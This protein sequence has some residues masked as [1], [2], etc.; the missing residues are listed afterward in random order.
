MTFSN[1]G[2]HLIEPASLQP[3]EIYTTSD[4]SNVSPGQIVKDEDGKT[5]M[6]GEIRLIFSRMFRV[7]LLPLQE[8]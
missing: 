5:Y 1:Q 4:L 2:G 6:V 3:I 7:S 8:A